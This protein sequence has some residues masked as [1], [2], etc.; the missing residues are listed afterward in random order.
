MQR[1][2]ILNLCVS[3]KVY[4]RGVDLYQHGHVH[5]MECEYDAEID[6][7]YADA[8]VQGSGYREYETWLEYDE[9]ED[10]IVDYDCSCPAQDN[11]YGM[12]KHGVALCLKA[13]DEN[14]LRPYIPDDPV[15]LDS[16]VTTDLT[17]MNLIDRHA[18][19]KRQD[20]QKANGTIELVPKLIEKNS[21]YIGDS[22]IYLTFRIG[23]GRLYVLRNLSNFINAVENEE[24]VSYGKQLSFVHN[25]S[26]FTK[27]TWEMICLIREI[28]ESYYTD[29]R[30][31]LYVGDD[32]LSRFL[33]LELGESIEYESDRCNEG[34]LLIVDQNPP[35]QIVIEP[36]GEN[37]YSMTVPRLRLV[38]G[39]EDVFVLYDNKAY[40]CDDQYLD[41]MLPVLKIA[42]HYSEIKY[43]VS[44]E[45]MHRLYNEVLIDMETVDALDKG[46]LTFEQYLPK[47]LQVSYY[48]DQSEQNVMVKI[49]GTYADETFNLLDTDQTIHYRDY[50]RERQALAIGEAYFSKENKKEH[51]LYFP[52]EDE[53]RRYQLFDTGISQMEKNGK[54]Y[55]SE[56]F[57]MRKIVR[58]PKARM[59]ISLES[60]LLSL[61]IDLDEFSK[62]ELFDILQSYRKKRKYYRLTSGD[63]LSLEDN[64]VSA[65]AQILEHLTLR[66]QDFKQEELSIPKY[67]ACYIDQVLQKDAGRLQVK[68]NPDYK[69]L[70]RNMKNVEDSDY[71][72]P[73]GL[74]GN[75]RGYQKT[76]YRWLRT[77]S[78]YGFGGILADDMGLGKTIQ[79]IAYLLARKEE[80]ITKP[81]LII[82]PAS[83]VYNWQKEL[84]H[85]APLLHVRIMVG[86]ASIRKQK[87]E[88]EDRDDVWITSY[89]TA[90][91][92]I[93][94]YQ[95]CHFDTAIIDEAQNIKNHNTQVARAVKLIS[96]DIR[97]AL[98]GTPIEN[99]LSELWSIFDY[100][101]PGILKSYEKFRNKYENPIMSGQDQNVMEELKKLVS[102][103]ILRR[104]K[105][106]VL[107]ELPD[108][109]EQVIYAQM[110]R[111]Q[112]KLYA[113]HANRLLMNLEQQTQE[114][115]RQDK[116]EIL[117]EL[118]RLRQICC[119][120]GLLYEDYQAGAC[121]VDMCEE[122]VKEAIEGNHKV[123]IFS[124]FTSIFPI[125]EER[126][127]KAG[128][129]YYELTGRT[130]KQK[131]M[132][133]VERFNNDDVPVFLISLKAGGTGLNLTSASIVIHFDPWWNL[134]A[135]NQ[136]TDRAHRIGQENQVVVLK[137]IVKDTVEEKIVELQKQKQEIADEI[138]GG[139]G[140]SAA[141][142]T[143]EDL[144]AILR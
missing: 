101:M 60:G 62:K 55:A 64:E 66:K 95:K 30:K 126:F 112:K 81:S 63:Y 140:I 70:I 3:K 124:Q 50:D 42:D 27:K 103:F 119:D 1:E 76:G 57:R 28:T 102:P 118:T 48:L 12:C 144:L 8:S 35:L 110:D 113:G 34:E 137:L 130:P 39:R 82:C 116:L 69:A 79:T 4:Q 92:D 75:L 5:A 90:K 121:K 97:F 56:R 14:Y 25:K 17:I 24:K 77:L 15:S 115:I 94:L 105:K 65:M 23:R 80:G 11:Y 45:D 109:V 10:I 84:E 123:L 120:P 18:R 36:I 20:G 31:E 9:K 6:R 132:Q 85:F 98:T 71:E 72:V 91:R 117:A 89:D 51:V 73:K 53:D 13:I 128:I 47:P 93:L 59:G 131:R 88:L 21:Y 7:W 26:V 22:D 38:E 32:L 134:A 114:Q 135:Q 142:L 83:L 141:K 99:R 125:L 86:S 100:L 52:V 136:A 61:K 41:K 68:R 133:M 43:K 29:I 16:V 74:C 143:R 108:K 40:H 104:V 46:T 139:E 33:M 37:D 67:F 127:E 49:M 2:E 129:S 19:K 87:F 122:L 78:E 111:E 106:D 58:S 44:G 107:K 138:L 96:A 54:V